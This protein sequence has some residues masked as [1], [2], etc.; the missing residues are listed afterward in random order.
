MSK[1]EESLNYRLFQN[2]IHVATELYVEQR[3]GYNLDFPKS[4]EEAADQIFAL[5][6]KIHASFETGL[7]LPVKEKTLLTDGGDDG[8]TNKD[9]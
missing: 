8:Q 3:R 9:K 4:F 2:C 7:R 1:I 6:K 5:A